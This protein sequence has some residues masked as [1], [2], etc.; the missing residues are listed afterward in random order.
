MQNFHDPMVDCLE[1]QGRFRADHLKSPACPTCGVIGKFT[2][3][4]EFNLMFRTQVGPI[5]GEG[6]QAY[7]RPETAQGIFIN[8]EN[9]LTSTLSTTAVR[10]CAAGQILPQR[11]HAGQLHLPHA[12]VRADGDGVSSSQPGD[13]PRL[14]R[15]AG[16]RPAGAVVPGPRHRP[17]QPAPRR[18]PGRRSSPTTRPARPTSST[19]I[20]W[21]WDELEGIANRTD[22]DLTTARPV[23]AGKR[24]DLL[25]QR[26][27]N[28]HIV[29]LRH[30]ARR[31]GRS[32]RRWPSSC[33]AY[34]GGRPTRRATTA[35]LLE[36]P[37]PHRGRSTVA[38]LPLSSRRPEARSPIS[39]SEVWG[40]HAAAFGRRSTTRRMSNR[41]ALPPP[42]RRSARRCASRST[43]TVARRRRR[44]DPGAGLARAGHACKI[45]A[46]VDVGA[47]ASAR[48]LDT[49]TLR[50]SRLGRMPTEWRSAQARRASCVKS[51]AR[52][53]RV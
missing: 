20:P 21:G 53:G 37:P 36:V 8:F 34:A 19:A 10:H 40:L 1:C 42:G 51:L 44:D 41:P 24:L 4:R 11:N 52:C 17:G 46:L 16:S 2:E 30:R 25:R 7:L 26:R 18:A 50:P 5:A 47:A 48:L 6:S 9:V 49:R 27:R 22:F 12:R 32:D 43:S 14:V 3:A 15:A 31:R 28:E 35:R 29:P 23:T 45:A 13:V 38:V 33:D 39:P